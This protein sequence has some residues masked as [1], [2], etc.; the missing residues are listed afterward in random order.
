[1]GHET[2]FT[3]ADFTADLRAPTPSAAAELVVPD[4]NELKR[5]VA[6]IK[7]SLRKGILQQINLYRERIDQLEKRILDPKKKIADYRLRLDDAANRVYRGFLRQIRDKREYLALIREGLNR[8]NPQIMI[9]KLKVKLEY[10][11][12]NLLLLMK[13]YMDNKE[14]K[15]REL[16]SSLNALSPLSILQR[17]YSITRSLPHYRIVKDV[18]EVAL[19][20]EVEIL[21]A[22]GTMICRVEE[23]R[24]NGKRKNI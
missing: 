12:D 21:L 20:Q 4:K 5:R 23:K 10:I 9:E 19:N 7:D 16:T 14:N 2:D 1:V 15:W 17:G 24:E 6:S 11:R 18:N 22:K 8:Y 3:I 13:N